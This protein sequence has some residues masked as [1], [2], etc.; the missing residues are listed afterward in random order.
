VRDAAILLGMLAGVDESDPATRGQPS[1]IIAGLAAPLPANALRG[2]RVGVMRD[3]AKFAP[4]V[5]E[6]LNRAVDALRTAGA[7]VIDPIKAPDI[8]QINE[9]EWELLCYEFKDG[10]NTWFASLGPE[11]RVKSLAE[12]IV[13]NVAH[14][15]EELRFFGQETLIT[16]QAKGPLTDHEYLDARALAQ[17]LARDEGIDRLMND[18]QLDAIVALTAGPAWLID[19]LNGDHFTGE[20]STLAAVAGYPSVTVPA[21]NDFGLPIGISFFG[22]AWTDV[23]L[24]A[25]A[26]DFE[27]RMRA[28]SEPEFRPTADLR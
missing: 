28:R 19:A 18:H 17:R 3:A 6:I 16:A 2:A 22:R 11:G 27:N 5:E 23:H 25:F 20:T 8:D 13:F 15:E 26:A 24:L 14:A 9:S 7:E 10:I 4:R 21:G 1:D 12:L